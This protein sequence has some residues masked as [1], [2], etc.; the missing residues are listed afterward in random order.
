M[1]L[2]LS[3]RLSNS[4]VWLYATFSLILPLLATELFADL[5]YH[6]VWGPRRKSWTIEMTLLSALMRN[7]GQ[8]SHLG[9]MVCETL[10]AASSSC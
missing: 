4:P 6:H 10:H 1:S 8:H 5:V 7:I 9:D 3:I 2:R